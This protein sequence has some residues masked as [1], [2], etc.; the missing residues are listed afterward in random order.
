MLIAERCATAAD[1]SLDLVE[2]EQRAG[3]ITDLSQA[4]EVAV[5]RH[6][7]AALALNRLD[8]ECSHVAGHG[9]GRSVEV[10]EG[11]EMALRQQR[12][13]GLAVF[14]RSDQAQRAQRAAVK[15]VLRRDEATATART[16]RELDDAVHRFG[17]G[18]HQERMRQHAVRE[19][20]QAFEQF[21]LRQVV[22]DVG[23]LHQLARLQRDRPYEL[24]V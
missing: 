14:R 21:E 18:V 24:R 7:H 22:E 6:V 3:G 5:R 4:G 1:A 16:V 13:V 10:V 19:G 9:T 17:A 8:D 11:Y 15:R 20:R 23:R 12:S 2:D